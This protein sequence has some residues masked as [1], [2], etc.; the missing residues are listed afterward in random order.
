MEQVLRYFLQNWDDIFALVAGILYLIFEVRQK[1]FMWFICIV[2]SSVT[3]YVFYTE[4]LYA[5]MTLNLY[6]VVTAFWGIWAWAKD[7]RKLSAKSVETDTAHSLQE[8]TAIHLRKLTMRPVLISLICFLCLTPL[9]K[10]VLV[11]LGD[12]NSMLDA[13]VFVLSVIATIWLVKSYLQQ[14]LLWILADCISTIMCLQQGMNL[15]AILY[16]FFTL[17]A[18][19]GYFHWK[20]HGVYV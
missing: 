14:W 6:Y 11:I 12:G 13:I 1:N 9:L 16:A 10:E 15:L 7:A 4:R 17:V 20:K 2:S 5:S 19:Y 18:V 3:A 8:K